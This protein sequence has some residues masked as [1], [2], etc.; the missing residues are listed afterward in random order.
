M[1]L[2]KLFFT[3]FGCIVLLTLLLIGLVSLMIIN[4]NELIESEQV[5]LES[6]KRADELRQ[7]SDDLT[8]FART[9]VVTGNPKY[10]KMYWDILKIRNGELARPSYYERIYWDYMAATGIKPRVDDKK[11]PLRKMFQELGFTDEE[12]AKLNESQ[13]NSDQLVLLETV[14]MNAMKGLYQDEAGNF[15]IKNKPDP[16]L[17]RNLMHSNEYHMEKA[18]IMKPIDEFLMLIE[19]RTNDKVDYH[20]ELSETYFIILIILTLLLVAAASVGY[21]FIRRKVAAPLIILNSNTKSISSGNL[22]VDIPIKK[23]H[24]EIGAL[25]NSFA[26]MASDLKNQINEIIESSNLLVIATTQISSTV[27]ELTTSSQET[28]TSISETSTTVDEVRQ[29]AVI[30]KE[31]AEEVSKNSETALLDSKEGESAVNDMHSKITNIKDQMEVIATSITELGEQSAMINGIMNTINNLAEQSNLLAVNAA[32]EASKAGEKGKGFAVV[33]NEVR[34]LAEQSK[35]ATKTV[36][37]ILDDIQ[38]ATSKAVMSTEQGGRTVAEGV[39]QVDKALEKIKLLSNSIYESSQ[40]AMQI[41][42]SAK[43]QFIGIDQIN[44]AVKSISEASKQNLQSINQ[45]KSASL[46]MKNLGEKLKNMV[47]FYKVTEANK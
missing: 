38:K 37:T 22:M 21:Y 31:R 17:A 39:Q 7:S 1:K 43:Q 12:F 41:G 24:D 35:E 8:R 27:A 40:S 20:I 46:E 11:I 32:I 29:T 33:A 16:E 9:Y 26:K 6:Y 5:R 36:R 3:I 4:Q 13:N 2:N 45:L 10:E 42:A 14:A 28:V 25:Y 18:S 15:T 34:S 19:K 23:G 30:A 47:S 44:L